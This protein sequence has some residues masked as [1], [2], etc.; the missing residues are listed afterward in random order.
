MGSEY[1]K[2]VFFICTRYAI[3]IATTLS[4][5]RDALDRDNDVAREAAPPPAGVAVFAEVD[6]LPRAQR[7]LPVGHGD[8]ERSPHDR[9]LNAQVSQRTHNERRP[10]GGCSLGTPATFPL[11]PPPPHTLSS[12]EHYTHSIP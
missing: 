1:S 8:V 4:I 5:R 10:R 12:N 9:A 11:A 7:Q 3:F 2:S 6:A